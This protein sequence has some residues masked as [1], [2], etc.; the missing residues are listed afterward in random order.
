MVTCVDTERLDA[1]WLGR[2]VDE[3]FASEIGTTGIDACG[4]NGEYHSFAFAG[5]AFRHAVRW[6]PG[7][8]R[9]DGRFIQLDVLPERKL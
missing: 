7:R 3:S 1:S 9:D 6:T 2:V 8:H 4:E 5:P